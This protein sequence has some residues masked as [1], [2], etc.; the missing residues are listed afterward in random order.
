MELDKRIIKGKRPLTC[1]DLKE[2]SDF[3]NKTGYFANEFDYFSDLSKVTECC[4][5]VYHGKL[6]G[7]KENKR[8][9]FKYLS[10]DCSRESSYRF[11]IP[12]EWVLPEEPEKKYRAF[13]LN[14]F[15]ERHKIG[16]T[17]TFRLKKGEHVPEDE[18]RV[19][20]T[21]LITGYE[22]LPENR[23]IPGKGSILL[24]G[25]PPTGLARLFEFYELENE[26][27]FPTVWQPFGIEIKENE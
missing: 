5:E 17:V 8:C 4:S 16:N 19:E 27:Y 13:T 14:E 18:C 11:F 15:L 23:D 1:F 25:C 6:L 7:I 12:E 10:M 2:A 9:V 3:L 24:G 26:Y 22:T 21:R 20:Y